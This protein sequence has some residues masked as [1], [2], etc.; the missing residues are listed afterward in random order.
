MAQ[1]RSHTSLFL[2]GA[3]AGAAAALLL[4]PSTRKVLLNGVQKVIDDL[5]EGDA[6]SPE[7]ITHEAGAVE[8]GLAGTRRWSDSYSGA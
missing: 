5:R 8:G 3:A 4:I 7:H 6:L 2:I 1:C